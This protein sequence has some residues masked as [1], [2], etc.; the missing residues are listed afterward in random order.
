MTDSI[1][2]YEITGPVQRIDERDTLFSREA[3]APGSEHERAYHARFPERAK[4]DR[5]LAR[6]IEN[7]MASTRPAD[8]WDR[9][10]YAAHFVTTAALGLPGMVDGPGSGLSVELSPTD[11]ALRLKAFA[12]SVGAD[13]VRIGPLCSEWVYSHR[14]ARPF[15]PE[16]Y[17]NAPYFGLS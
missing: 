11:A 9:A 4:V 16:P 1:P 2:P 3:L 15:F 5:E 14:G 13:E 17:V 8:T 6:F 10:I 7:K 12:G